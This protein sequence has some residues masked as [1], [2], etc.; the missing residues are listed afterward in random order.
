[1][2]RTADALREV[3]HTVSSVQLVLNLLHGL[4]S[5]F[6]NTADIIANSS[7]LPDFQVSHQHAPR[8]GTLPWHRQ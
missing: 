8:Q 3:G 2:K 1:M 5:R 4:N 6:A 7:P